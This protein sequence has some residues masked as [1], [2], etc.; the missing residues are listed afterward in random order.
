MGSKFQL[1][2]DE[3]ERIKEEPG[4]ITDF[5]T[6]DHI[7]DDELF[8]M[9]NALLELSKGQINDLLEGLSKDIDINPNKNKF[10][11][12]SLQDIRK[13]RY[14]K[15][16]EEKIISDDVK[17][18]GEENTR[19]EENIREAREEENRREVR[20][21]ENRREVGIDIDKNEKYKE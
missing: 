13:Y 2:P 9:R 1:T 21:E 16:I 20:E 3:I 12:I 15:I 4:T 14:R 5:P 8:E 17:T 11:S 7:P 10:N 18:L 19:E 6:I